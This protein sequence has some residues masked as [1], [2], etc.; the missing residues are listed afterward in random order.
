MN[1][2]NL[3]LLIYLLLLNVI[4]LIFFQKKYNIINIFDQPKTKIKNHK[5]NMPV[6]GGMLFFSNFIV[7]TILDLT[8]FNF[9]FLVNR[10]SILLI[11]CTAF[12]FIL[13]ILDDIYNIKPSIKSFFIIFFSSI[14][15]LTN[16]DLII[17]EIKLDNLELIFLHNFSFFFTLVCIFIFVNSYN[18]L[19]GADLNI[20][21]YNFFIL[22]F[23]YYKTSFNNFFF[24]FLIVNSFFFVLNYKKQTFFGNNGSY[25]FSFLISILLIYCFK[26]YESINEEDVILVTIFP[27]IELVRLFFLRIVKNK[28]PFI[29]DNN[30]FHHLTTKLFGKLNGII[31]SQIYVVFCI[32]VDFIF[33]LN[34]WILIIL[35]LFF[36][37]ISIH[38]MTNKIFNKKK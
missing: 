31:V 25:F 38:I 23:L 8:Y 22:I 9:F 26:E 32:L 29:G 15:L 20:A 13:G 12:I 36:Y 17:N 16:N 30:H 11:F 7:F 2:E 4:L 19:D 21:F 1:T 28:S 37:F 10:F 27:I 6:Y 14:I 24:I 3:I 35:F 5:I 34:L 18:M 33:N